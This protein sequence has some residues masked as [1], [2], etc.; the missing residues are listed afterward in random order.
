MKPSNRFSVNNL[1]SCANKKKIA[2]Y[3]PNLPN[4]NDIEGANR[5]VLQIIEGLGAL[6]HDIRFISFQ[7]VFRFPQH[8]PAKGNVPP[9]SGSSDE[10]IPIAG[11]QELTYSFS[12]SNVRAN[13]MAV[14]TPQGGKMSGKSRGMIEGFIEQFGPDLAIFYFNSLV[15]VQVEHVLNSL[16]ALSPRTKIIAFMEES[17]YS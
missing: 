15:N 3:A 12:R 6:G 4:H 2:F 14:D 16:E 7:G 17:G 9:L 11:I 1:Y 8:T 13:R 10:I 5:R